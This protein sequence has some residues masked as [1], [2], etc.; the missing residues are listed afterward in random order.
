MAVTIYHNPRCSTSRR[1]LE[2]LRARGI[3]P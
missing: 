2:L 1:T 3:E